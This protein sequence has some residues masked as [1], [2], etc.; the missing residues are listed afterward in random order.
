MIFYFFILGDSLLLGDS[1][2][3]ERRHIESVA[4][5][6]HLLHDTVLGRGNYSSFDKHRSSCILL[7]ATNSK[8]NNYRHT[9][10]P[11]SLLP[12][13]TGKKWEMNNTPA[14]ST[15][16]LASK[17]LVCWDAHTADALPTELVYSIC[18]FLDLRSLFAVR[19]AHSGA[20]A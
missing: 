9:H 6:R 10:P 20:R 19:L 2:S 8:Q 17:T 13:T 5:T 12:V 15:E 16:E 3:E 18:C 11:F 7:A 1:A 14:E 4:V